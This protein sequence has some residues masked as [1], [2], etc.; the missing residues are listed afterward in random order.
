MGGKYLWGTVIL[1]GLLAGCTGGQRSERVTPPAPT[2]MVKM[3]LESIA[4][5]GELGSATDEVQSQLESLKSSDAAKADALLAELKELTGLTDP[6]AIRA[7]AKAM[8]D[9][10]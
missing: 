10:L 7:K 1:A 4:A 9:K 8:A 6:A 2:S 5:S 3:A